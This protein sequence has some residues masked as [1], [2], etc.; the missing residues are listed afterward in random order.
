MIIEAREDTITLRG[1]VISNIWPAI[2]AAAALLLEKHPAGII[3]DCSA[4][5]ELTPKG[6]ETFADAFKYIDSHKA[7]ILLTGLSR[8]LEE[9]GKAV[10]EVRSQL[11]IAASVEEARA[12][13]RLEEI[14]PRRGKARVAAVVPIVG[15]WRRAVWHADKLAKGENC[16]IHL[17]DLIKVPRTLP[18]GSPMPER[19]AAG[20]E[21]LNKAQ[22]EVKETGLRGFTHVERVRSES[23]GLIQFTED[24]KGDLIVVSVTAGDP[25]TPKIEEPEALRL[26]EEAKCEVSLIGGTFDA[27]PEIECSSALLPVVGEWRH[28]LE[29]SCKLVSGRDAS[30]KL[31][32][33]VPIPRTEPLDAPRPEAM[34]AAAD[35]EKEAQR[36]GKRFGIKTS[37]QVERVRDPVLGFLKFL[38]KNRCSLVVVGVTSESSEGYPLAQSMALTLLQKSPCEMVFLRVGQERLPS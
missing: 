23:S 10:P 3:I 9:I 16:E 13:L 5:T 19:E 15:N 22:M 20:Q 6:A 4:I 33:L 11:P 34:E 25:G 28:A 7:R 37:L 12:S 31:V 30:I 14:I 1:A 29:H 21:R 36:I 24:L 8:E 38:E 17:V 27:D 35:F 2:Q 32:Y 18:I 26:I